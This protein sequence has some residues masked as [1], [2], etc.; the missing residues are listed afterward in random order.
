M[1]T[2]QMGLRV[3]LPVPS[4]CPALQND[5]FQGTW[6][7]TGH[8]TPLPE[9]SVVPICKWLQLLEKQPQTSA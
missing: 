8:G 1:P 2:G 5:L 9:M 3:P 6:A 7:G 4:P